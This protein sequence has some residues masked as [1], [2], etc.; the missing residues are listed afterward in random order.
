MFCLSVRVP[1]GGGVPDTLRF[2]PYQEGF[3]RL[4]YFQ[5]YPGDWLKDA[6]LRRC[7]PATRGF[8]IDLICV[9][10]ECPDRGVLA[11][12]GE[13]WSDEEIA[14][15]IPGDTYQ[16]LL[17]LQELLRNQIVRRNE[18]G[19]IY[20]R[21]LVA[22]EVAREKWRTRQTKRRHGG[23]HADV[24]PSVTPVSRPSS[25]S[26]S[27]SIN[28]ESKPTPSASGE[29]IVPIG[30][31][32][33]FTDMRRRIRKPLDARAGELLREEL[34]RL[35][36]LGHDPVAV[37]EQSIRNGWSGVF[38]LKGKVDGESFAEKRSRTSAEAIKDIFAGDD[39]VAG[40]IRRT[41]PPAN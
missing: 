4:P 18:Q 10:F 14:Q 12:N 33:D 38:P 2:H 31:W 32:L 25:S 39:G 6:N 36:G 7:S 15:A 1:I 3:T 28:T 30:L 8:W 35:Q 23:C 20:S 34:I 16:N 29:Q 19:A 37:V 41:L 17:A 11:T 21:R 13:A 40:P 9:M 27:S 22:D 26:Y 5:F 24:T